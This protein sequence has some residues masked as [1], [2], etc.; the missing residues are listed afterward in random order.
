MFLHRWILYQHF[1]GSH[2]FCLNYGSSSSSLMVRYVFMCIIASFRKSSEVGGEMSVSAITSPE[3]VGRT[4][5][6]VAGVSQSQRKLH[7]V[8]HHTVCFA[9]CMSCISYFSVLV[10]YVSSPLYSLVTF[11]EGNS[12]ITP[13]RVFFSK[14]QPSFIS[15][16]SWH[17]TSHCGKNVL[18]YYSENAAAFWLFPR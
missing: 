9:F 7:L 4:R 11:F 16:W 15:L 5:S 18:W 13:V 14:S 2:C 17:V 3:R 10:L 1:G 8:M 12:T 6:R